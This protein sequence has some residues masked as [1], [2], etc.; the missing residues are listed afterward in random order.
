MDEKS[1][2]AFCDAYETGSITGAAEEAFVTRQALSRT[3]RELESELGCALFERGASGVR[4]TP[5]GQAAY[6]HARRALEECRAMREDAGKYREGVAGALLLAV[7]PNAML[8]LP[9]DLLARYRA[10]RPGVELRTSLSHGSASLEALASGLVDAV[11]SVPAGDGRFRYA[12]IY[13]SELCAVFRLGDPAAGERAGGALPECPRAVRLGPAALEGMRL[14]GVDSDNPVERCVQEYLRGLGVS[15]E[16]SY[17]YPSGALAL[18]A[19]ERGLGV[20]LVERGGIGQF[21]S[22]GHAVVVF[23][24]PGAPEWEVG[25]T[26]RRESLRARIAEDFLAFATGSLAQGGAAVG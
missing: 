10:A 24:G 26:W 9:Q 16:V 14:F 7:E 11:L 3:L 1:L 19:M 20:S 23:T 18:D 6:P 22:P 13:R 12:P 2:R 8:S 15:A 4:P 17:D 25:L 21:D 5:F